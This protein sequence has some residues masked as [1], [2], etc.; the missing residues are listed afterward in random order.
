MRAWLLLL[1]AAWIPVEAVGRGSPPRQLSE[2]AAEPAANGGNPAVAPAIPHRLF[3]TTKDGTPEKLPAAL[4]ANLERTL[5]LNPEL[6]VT[7]YDDGACVALLNATQP[8]AVALFPKL[9]GPNKADLCRAAY[10]LEHGGFYV[11]V[12]VAMQVPFVELVGPETTF[13]TVKNPDYDESG[14]DTGLNWALIASAPGSAIFREV[15]RL[16]VASPPGRF[17]NCVREVCPEEWG[18]TTLDEAVQN[19]CPDGF[20]APRTTDAVACGERVRLYAEENMVHLMANMQADHLRNDVLRR[21]VAGRKHMQWLGLEFAIFAENPRLDRARVPLRLIAY[22]RFDDC[23]AWNCGADALTT[24][25]PTPAATTA[26]PLVVHKRR[27]PEARP[28]PASRSSERRPPAP[29]R[30]A[31]RVVYHQRRPAAPRAAPPAGTAEGSLAERASLG[32]RVGKPIVFALALALA[33]RAGERFFWGAAFCACSASMT[34]CNK[35]AVGTAPTVLAAVQMSFA[36]VA[37][38]LSFPSLGLTAAN[39]RELTRWLP[40][41]VLFVAMLQTSLVGFQFASVSTVIVMRAMQP[42]YGLILESCLGTAL[43]VGKQ[44]AGCCVLLFGAG[45][46][47][48]GA[49][50]IDHTTRYGAV[51]L[52]VNGLLATLDRVYQKS[53]LSKI[54]L[55]AG[56]LLLTSNAG[57][58]LLL[59]ALLP[60][61]E[62]LPSF[63]ARAALW[64][65][66]NSG[67]FLAVLLSCVA[68]LGI[69]YTGLRFQK[70]VSASTFLAAQT[71]LR[72]FL[73]VLD[74]VLLGTRLT[75]TSMVGLAVTLVGTIMC[76]TEPKPKTAAPSE[77]PATK[78]GAGEDA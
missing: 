66:G 50:S 54:Q 39:A 34:V 57:G 42:L 51:V 78:P 26:A 21:A 23:K 28:R 61:R 70:L 52:A 35:L 31:L 20:P 76:W 65:H 71:G 40:V 74:H 3:V 30:P 62:E 13:M 55:S 19:L 9:W 75:H 11:D 49:S 27:L 1:N 68:G 15:I 4:R 53:Q 5:A 7:W 36:V 45:V 25:A 60:W 56:A 14:Y 38:L 73:A 67:D 16:M 64:T 58:L 32:A 22:S 29:A 44:A 63:S 12:D 77:N 72:A 2:L 8:A 43:D 37:L 24:P 48:R 10:L 41:C 47:F 59:L 46:Y 18:P 6:E 33:A 17:G 69:G